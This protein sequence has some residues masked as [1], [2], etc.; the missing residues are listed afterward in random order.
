MGRD[1]KEW[2][3]WDWLSGRRS[4]ATKGREPGL[5]VNLQP[6]IFSG[7]RPSTPPSGRRPSTLDFRIFFQVHAPCRFA[8]QIGALRRGQ[9]PRVLVHQVVDFTVGAR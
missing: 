8:E 6:L 9:C 1:G 5:W 4:V 3:I 2:E 7:C